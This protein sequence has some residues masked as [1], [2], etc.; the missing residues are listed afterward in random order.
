M[1]QP[2]TFVT[3]PKKICHS[4]FFCPFIFS[5]SSIQSNPF[6][7]LFFVLSFLH[8][9]SGPSPYDSTYPTPISL[10]PLSSSSSSSSFPHL[11]MFLLFYFKK[12]DTSINYKD[13]TK[14]QLEQPA[15]HT[16]KTL[17]NIQQR[18]KEM[19]KQY[20]RSQQKKV[21]QERQEALFTIALQNHPLLLTLFLASHLKALMINSSGLINDHNLVNNTIPKLLEMINSSPLSNFPNDNFQTLSP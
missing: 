13:T 15:T 12:I 11:L 20:A 5:V 18:T 4:F 6:P 19:T 17:I 3:P 7:F 10:F 8:F 2:Q 14:A 9:S 16:Q 21:L 1:P